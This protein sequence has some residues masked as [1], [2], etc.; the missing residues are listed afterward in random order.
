M[1]IEASHE[2]VIT[3]GK[4]RLEVLIIDGKYSFKIIADNSVMIKPKTSNSVIIQ[5]S[6]KS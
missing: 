4:L 6:G 5:N 2:D 3:F 1:R